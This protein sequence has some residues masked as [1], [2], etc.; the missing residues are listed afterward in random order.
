ME[1]K[2]ILLVDD[3]PSYAKMVREWIRDK[4][5]T[6][7]VTAG[8]KAIK[9]LSKHRVDMILLDYEMPD[10]D[11][12]KVLEMLR[13]DPATKDIPVVFLTGMDSREGIVKLLDLKPDGFLLKTAAKDDILN[14]LNE[15]LK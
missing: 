10:L 13:K 2:R 5:R 8:T 7:V 3:D 6:D 4:Y 15:R 12:S 11:G 1:K 14:F 9:F